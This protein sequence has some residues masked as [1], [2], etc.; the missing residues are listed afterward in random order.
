[1]WKQLHGRQL[2][3]MATIFKFEIGEGGW[4]CPDG[5]GKTQ[6]LHSSGKAQHCGGSW[7]PEGLSSQLQWLQYYGGNLQLVVAAGG[8]M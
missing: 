4:C 3:L 7:W 2:S 5:G 6:D 8:Y 1:M